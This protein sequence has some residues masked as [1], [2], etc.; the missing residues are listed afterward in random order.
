MEEQN[1][2]KSVTISDFIISQKVNAFSDTY[3]NTENESTADDVF[4]DSKLRK[5]FHAY[6]LSMG[7]PLAEYINLLEKQ[8]FKM[9]T[10]ITGEPA[11]FV[12]LIQVRNNFTLENAFEKD[13]EC[14]K[15]KASATQ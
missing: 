4:T 13:D 12:R 8:G 6:P 1:E 2:S 5:Y 3:I 7:D 14:D 10:S 11:I 9:R 15:T